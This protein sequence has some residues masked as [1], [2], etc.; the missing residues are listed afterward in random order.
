MSGRERPACPRPPAGQPPSGRSHDEAS[1]SLTL[2]LIRP[3]HEV[4]VPEMNLLAY[5]FKISCIM[6]ITTKFSNSINN[7]YCYYNS[8]FCRQPRS[9]SCLSRVPGR[10]AAAAPARGCSLPSPTA[11]A[12]AGGGTRPCRRTGCHFCAFPEA[13]TSLERRKE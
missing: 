6:G 9:R 5:N 2:V 7:F 4:Q 13:K 1:A 12:A 3:Q 8:R 10:P 11:R